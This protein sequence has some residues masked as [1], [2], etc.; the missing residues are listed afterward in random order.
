MDKTTNNTP[1]IPKVIKRGL[2]NE[3]YASMGG[4]AK[5][6]FQKW[7]R[8][9]RAQE[10]TSALCLQNLQLASNLRKN[11]LKYKEAFVSSLRS[12]LTQEAPDS[13]APP[14]VSEAPFYPWSLSLNSWRS[15][16]EVYG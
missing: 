2:E 1:T 6:E 7:W 16:L 11:H 5:K 12:H 9:E 14:D 4:F 13:N 15:S 10:E 3:N 8:F